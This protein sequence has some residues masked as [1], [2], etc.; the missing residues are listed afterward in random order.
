MQK[1]LVSHLWGK[2]TNL[3]AKAPRRRFNLWK[4]GPVS[5]G[6][7]AG[8]P[9]S[10]CLPLL[11]PVPSPRSDHQVVPQPGP[12]NQVVPFWGTTTH[13]ERA[14]GDFFSQC[15]IVLKTGNSANSDTVTKGM[16]PA[17]VAV[18]TVVREARGP[19][20]PATGQ[21]Q[22]CAHAGTGEG[23]WCG[24]GGDTPHLR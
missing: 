7:P 4:E 6:G 13:R 2:W 20:C 16:P 9:A 11:W 22:N 8:L 14:E 1:F 21:T 24:R 19:S 10:C 5:I 3:G 17:L 12:P 15:Y 18:D 23:V